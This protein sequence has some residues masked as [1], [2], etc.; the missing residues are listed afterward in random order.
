[1]SAPEPFTGWSATAHG[2]SETSVRYRRDEVHD[3]LYITLG[4]YSHMDIRIDMT[5]S[6]AQLE[7]DRDGLRKLAAVAMQLA[8]EITERLAGRDLAEDESEEGQ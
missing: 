2:L 1:M 5:A 8:A 3:A 7:R 4:R 6:T